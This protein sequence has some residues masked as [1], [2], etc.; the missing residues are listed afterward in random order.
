MVTRQHRTHRFGNS[1]APKCFTRLL[2][3][4]KKNKN[5]VKWLTDKGVNKVPDAYLAAVGNMMHVRTT[6]C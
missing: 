2:N 6:I 4:L 1:D 3:I 5:A